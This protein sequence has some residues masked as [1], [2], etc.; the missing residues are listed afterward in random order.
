MRLMRCTARG[1]SLLEEWC[2]SSSTITRLFYF[3]FLNEY[4]KELTFELFFEDGGLS[5][6]TTKEGC[7]HARGYHQRQVL[8]RKRD[9]LSERD[10]APPL[11]LGHDYL[12]G[13][14]QE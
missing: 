4:W 12:L 11:R 9:F 13:R 7:R 14:A 2:V 10:S 3:V 8:D 1:L 5:G 6:E